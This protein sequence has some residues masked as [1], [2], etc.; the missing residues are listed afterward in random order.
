MSG[1]GGMGGV[2]RRAARDADAARGGAGRRRAGARTGR[3]H[4]RGRVGGGGR[5]GLD[6]QQVLEIVGVYLSAT[7]WELLFFKVAAENLVVF[8]RS[9]Q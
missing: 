9:T 1:V 4:H 7:I 8:G 2:V 5:Q 3:F 6:S